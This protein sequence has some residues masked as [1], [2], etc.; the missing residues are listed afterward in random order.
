M[1]SFQRLAARIGAAQLNYHFN[2]SL[3][4]RYLYVQTSKCACTYLKAGL[5]RFELSDQ[6]F[7][8]DSYRHTK[9]DNIVADALA[10]GPHQVVNRS[11]FIK[12]YQ[13]GVA[14][15]EQMLQD[16]ASWKFAVVRNPYTRILSAYL[17]TVKGRRQPL[18]NVLGDIAKLQGV[19]PAAVDIEAID[20]ELFLRGLK[21][22]VE[23][24]GW[25][26]VDQHYR[27]QH[28]HLSDDIVPYTTIYR[29]ENLAQ[30][31]D[32][33]LQRFGLPLPKAQRGA[34]TTGANSKDADYYANSR[35]LA[36]VEELY[37]EDLQRF[38]Y[39]APV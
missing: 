25:G 39:R 36:L 17:D 28:F 21:Q 9:H 24:S 37:R 13:L 19:E 26:G 6:Q 35:C 27:Q 18:L 3:Q 33:F 7:F 2:F 38:D 22:R 31:E 1:S 23:R 15:F 5:T 16:L 11:V 30:L 12:P 10:N 8:S 34:H 4:H 14:L 32:D 29:V 20:F